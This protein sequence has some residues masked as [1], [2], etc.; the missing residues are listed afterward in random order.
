MNISELQKAVLQSIDERKDA[1]TAAG[2]SIWDHPQ[3][4]FH[5]D[6]AADK[7]CAI[8]SEN[9]FTVE[10]PL[11]GMPTAFRATYGSGKPVIAYLGEY[12]ALSALSQQAGS[13]TKSPI[14]SG[15]PGHGCGHNL[16]GVGSL[17]A[18]LAVKDAIAA[19]KE[20][21][22]AGKISIPTSLN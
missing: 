20:E 13:L 3:I 6:Y 16:L 22:K 2:D 9:G 8:L 19:L 10:R 14:E 18:A 7:L 12:D 11:D 15:A 5:E 1:L 4:N 21:V 17:G